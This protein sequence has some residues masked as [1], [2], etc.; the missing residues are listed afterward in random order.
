MIGTHN[1]L[2]YLPPKNKLY[3]LFKPFWRCQT[4][5]IWRQ[6][7]HVKFFDIRIIFDELGE[8]KNAAHGL[9]DLDVSQL[10]LMTMLASIKMQN[11]YCRI[12]I[13]RGDCSKINNVLDSVMVLLKDN[14]AEIRIKDGWELLYKNPNINLNI[15]DMSF[16]PFHSD[17]PWW[18]EWT[19]IFKYPIKRWVKKHRA[20]LTK[21][22]IED[23]NTVYFVD[24]YQYYI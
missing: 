15:V 2:T 24:Y 7:D 13:E 8:I 17:R 23:P 19:N 16:V 10:G 12:I 4:R 21:E 20:K 1:S 3:G 22:Q 9:V 18:K 5:S 11:A 6:L 14:I